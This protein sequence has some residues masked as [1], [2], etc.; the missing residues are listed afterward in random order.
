MLH[1]VNPLGCAPVLT[2]VVQFQRRVLDFACDPALVTPVDIASVEASFSDPE[3]SK[4]LVKRLWGRNG[5]VSKTY[6]AIMEVRHHV[7]GDLTARERILDAFD[8]DVSFVDS[9]HDPKFKF[10]YWSTLTD[11]DRSAI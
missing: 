8:H 10:S 4:W 1:R 2:K 9:L 5:K 6:D 7:K 11:Q 3:V